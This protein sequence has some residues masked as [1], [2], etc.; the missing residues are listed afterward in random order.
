[1][2]RQKPG[3]SRQDYGTPPELLNAIR[4]AF[5]VDFWVDLAA[6]DSNRIC[7]LYYGVEQ[8]SL[9]MPW[10]ARF[11][12]SRLNHVAWLNHPFGDS[13][14]WVKKCFQETRQP[15]LKIVQLV[16]ASVGSNW[17]R[18]YVHGETR[19]VFLNG[20][21][22]FVGEHDPYP[23]DCALLFWGDEPGYEIWSWK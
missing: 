10:A 6:D 11:V 9:L 20:R 7:D 14:L 13:D 12:P 1:M 15:G 8:N 18:D 5:N 16:P 2:P 4:I 21:I 23:K 3:A 17:W 22:T 19:V